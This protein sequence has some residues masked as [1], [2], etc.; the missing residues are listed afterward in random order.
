MSDEWTNE[1]VRDICARDGIGAPDVA[2]GHRFDRWLAQHDAELRAEIA[3]E[4]RGELPVQLAE[5]SYSRHGW[6]A[7][8]QDWGPEPDA[9]YT[10]VDLASDGGDIVGSIDINHIAE[11]AANIAERSGK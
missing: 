2:N 5:T 8:A 1:R 4:L 11:H 3:A 6:L 7:D 9:L 10:R